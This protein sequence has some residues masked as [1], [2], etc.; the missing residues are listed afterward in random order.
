MWNGK[1]AHTK[2]S[3]SLTQQSDSL[4]TIDLIQF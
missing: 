1:L 4:E 3:F 2:E